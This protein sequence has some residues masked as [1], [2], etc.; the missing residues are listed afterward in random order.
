MQGAVPPTFSI[1]MPGY[2]DV[3]SKEKKP[4]L[5]AKVKSSMDHREVVAIQA[6]PAIWLHLMGASRAQDAAAAA[7]SQ[8]PR[9][10][11][12]L[13][14]WRA[15]RHVVVA[16]H[17]GKKGSSKIFSVPRD[18][19]QEDKDAIFKEAED[20]LDKGDGEDREEDGEDQQEE[21]DKEDGDDMEDEDKEEAQDDDEEEGDV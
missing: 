16:R 11:P 1:M 3:D 14:A 4:P 21:D 20:W 12:K 8:S 2:T 18:A 19:S 13:V 6:D 17:R 15:D 10:H 9:K 5:A 7:A